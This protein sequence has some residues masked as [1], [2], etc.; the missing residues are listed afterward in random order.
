[1]C[2]TLGFGLDLTLCK[3]DLEEHLGI[4]QC[5]GLVT[6]CWTSSPNELHDDYLTNDHICLFQ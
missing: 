5:P 6:I 2:E 3:T 1:M 4:V